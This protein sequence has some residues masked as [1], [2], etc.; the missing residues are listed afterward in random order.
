MD[1]GIISFKGK[2]KLSERGHWI[3]CTGKRCAPWP[4]RNGLVIKN[5]P[6][7]VQINH[8][9]HVFDRRLRQPHWPGQS[10][11]HTFKITDERI[12]CISY[13]IH[14][15]IHNS[16]GYYCLMRNHPTPNFV[17]SRGGEVS[18]GGARP[19]LSSSNSNTTLDP[20]SKPGTS[21]IRFNGKQRH[22]CPA[23]IN[24]K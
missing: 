16:S 4:T 19:T 3:K 12:W 10:Y 1:R 13:I 18:Y 2:E 14:C 15:G 22:N 24:P 9:T 5:C 17:V 11:S 7:H 6:S 21:D 20:K 23:H 8:V